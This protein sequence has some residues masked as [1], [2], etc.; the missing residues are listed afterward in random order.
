MKEVSCKVLDIFFREL[1]RSGEPLERL[2]DGTG[3]SVD[4]LRNKKER[5]EWSEFVRVMDN[6]DTI[7]TRDDYIRIGGAFFGNK[8]LTSVTV[9]GRLLFTAKDFYRWIAKKRDG[10]GNQLFT[11]IDAEWKDVGSSDVEVSLMLQEGYE[12]CPAFFHVSHGAFKDVPKLLGLGS[13]DVE[14]ELSP[15]GA[16]YSISV[17]P[18]GGWLQR[19]K[20]AIIFPFIARDVARELK[21]ANE[22]LTARYAELEDYRNNLEIKVE[23]RTRELKEANEALT[24][25]QAARDQI[26]ANIN[27]EIRTPLSVILLGTR[28]ALGQDDLSSQQRSTLES[29]SVNADR[30]LHMV[31]G[32]LLLSA[33]REDRLTLKMG[34]CDLAQIIADVSK[35]MSP[36]AEDTGLTLLYSGPDVL[37]GRVDKTAMERAVANLITNAIKF[38]SEG[39]IEVALIADGAD[40]KIRVSDTGI[41]VDEAFRDKLFERFEQGRGPVRSGIKGSGIGL[42]I[43]REIAKAHGGTVE[44][45]PNEPE[46]SIFEITLPGVVDPAL[47]VDDQQTGHVT[48]ERSRHKEVARILESEE[49]ARGTILVAEDEPGLLQEIGSILRKRHRVLL[50]PDGAIAFE[51]AQEHLPDM[52]VTDLQM[53]HMNGF[54]LA[55]AFKDLPGNRLAPVVLLTAH[56]SLEDRLTA[57]EAG[58]IDYVTKPFEA[59]ELT[60]RVNAQL[61]IRDMAIKLAQSEKLA[62]LGTLSAG[63]AHEFRNPANTVVNAIEPLRAM[64]P[65]E[66]LEEEE[67][68]GELFEVLQSCADQILHLSNQLLGY[69]KHQ[70]LALTEEPFQSVLN[71]AISIVAPTI[72]KV[73]LQQRL[74]DDARLH[75]SAPFLAQA[76]ANLLENGAHAAG[77]GGWVGVRTYRDEGRFVVEVTD[78][79]AG[80][81]PELRERIFEP[82]FTTKEAGKGTGLGLVSARDVAEQHGGSLSV[83][84]RTGGSAFRMELPIG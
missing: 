80:V 36:A 24:E 61:R 59:A 3:F 44:Y 56:G 73:D 75:C 32:L 78:S 62:S 20:R 63:L 35:A 28:R 8:L 55:A 68:V 46:G 37:T 40:A 50:A 57:F 64:Y 39:D 23:E 1:Q 81:A 17:P 2:A 26:F 76:L 34:A 12:Q 53:P 16:V 14:C 72:E 52:L 18:G 21:A 65:E 33:G 51:L 45:R 42:P 60:A 6:A 66:M 58:A 54:E 4:F 70:N 19:L 15:G 29:I 41:G 10:V 7:W 30:L 77:P 84:D 67:G 38:T 74:D 48:V 9:A 47:Q 71:R 43:V 31:E 79:G 13:A 5:L 25:A 69:S 83:V 82:F 22:E 49:P 11:C 27:H